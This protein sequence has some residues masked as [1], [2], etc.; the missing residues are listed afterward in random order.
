MRR[1]G[2]IV[3]LVA[4]LAWIVAAIVLG[5]PDLGLS[6]G[7]ATVTAKTAPSCLPTTFDHSASLP[8]TTVDV[9]PEPESDTANPHTQISF[10]GTD[11]ADL[12]DVSVVGSESGRH[13]GRVS[14]Y[15]QGGGGSFVPARPFDP[16]ERVVVRAS[17]GGGAGARRIEF[18]FR[19][20]TPYPT[21]DVPSFPN[22]SAA[23]ADYQSFHTLPSVQAPILN[24]TV[25]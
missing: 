16:G 2:F 24:V 3:L 23:P 17:I 20:D 6:G 5:S 10:L 14:G 11:A 22:P 15:S 1:N 7:G 4:L 9:S 13:D 25:P 12:R 19:V 18:G 21:A 8:G